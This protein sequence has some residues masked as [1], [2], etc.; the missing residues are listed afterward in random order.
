MKKRNLAYLFAVFVVV[1]FFVFP[2]ATSHAETL[3][4]I[5][6]TVDGRPL[7]LRELN[8]F[9]QQM[10][11]RAAM[12]HPQGAAGM[13]QRDFLDALIMSKMI[14]HEVETQGLSAKAE[15][16]DS[17]IQRIKDQGGLDEAQLEQALADQG[18]SMEAYR[19]Q[20]REEIE[21]ALLVNREIGSKVN[22]TPQD[23]QRYIDANAGEFNSPDQIRI[24][25]IFLPL[26]PDAPEEE[27]KRVIGSIE[28]IHTR[29][30]GGE[31]FAALATQHSLGPGA[32]Q[33][34]DLGF[35]EKGQMAYEIEDVAFSLKEGEVSQPFRTDTGVHLIKVEEIR[36]AGTEVSDT[37]REEIRKRLYDQ[38]LAERYRVWFQ[39]DLRFRHHVELFL[40]SR[41]GTPY[42]GIRRVEDAFG[43]ANQ[44]AVYTE[45]VEDDEETYTAD[46]EAET[47]RGAAKKPKE[48]KGFFSRL[49]SGD[50]DEEE[51]AAEDE[52]EVEEP[53][54]EDEEKEDKEGKFL[55][56]F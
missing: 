16:I 43:G 15:D 13:T 18:M 38:K 24:R 7:T 9:S 1:L 52:E 22:V 2:G 10:G 14:Q 3:N 39:D 36:R 35:F 32:E 45:D 27:E 40:S 41:T 11:D 5:V 47:T 49:F 53:T 42:T 37:S 55:G 31:D 21:R 17:Y 54:A 46:E 29:A 8:I 25:H 50:D 51:I 56:L 4:R 12:M 23:V 20:I 19:Q 30:V 26:P 44:E 6:A 34:G 28:D 33:G 48:E